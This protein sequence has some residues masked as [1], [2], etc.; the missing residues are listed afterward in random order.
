[1]SCGVLAGHGHGETAM[2]DNGMMMVRI[3]LH[4]KGSHWDEVIHYLHD[5]ARVSGVTVYRGIS[6]FG[7]SGEYHSASLLDLSLDLPVVI[8]FFDEKLK[9][10][11]VIDDLGKI[12]KPGHMV[13]WTVDSNTN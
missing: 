10:Q 6:G 2:N 1:M 5:D 11:G 12:V 4:E 9:L 3:Y 7:E 13:Y 8:E